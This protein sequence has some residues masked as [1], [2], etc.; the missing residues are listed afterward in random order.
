VAKSY[1]KV[2][3]IARRAAP[4]QYPL[5]DQGYANFLELRKAEVRRIPLLGNSVNKPGG[6][7]RLRQPG[8][9]PQGVGGPERHVPRVEQIEG[10]QER[11]LSAARVGAHYQG[12][13]LYAQTTPLEACCDP[14]KAHLI[15]MREPHVGADKDGISASPK[16]RNTPATT[17]G[18]RAPSRGTGR[19][20]NL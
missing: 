3:I 8:R 10:P 6:L 9:V 14:W 1:A 5:G 4:V 2:V 16:A 17:S 13:T 11:R 7:D 19:S 12:R 15:I 18:F 20:Q